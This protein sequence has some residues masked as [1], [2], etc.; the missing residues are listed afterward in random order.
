MTDACRGSANT[1]ADRLA[2]LRRL[3]QN[4]FDGSCASQPPSFVETLRDWYLARDPASGPEPDALRYLI[5]Q[6]EGFLSLAEALLQ[7]LLCRNTLTTSEEELWGC[8][9]S[10]FPNP[11]SV[12]GT[13]GS[14]IRDMDWPALLARLPPGFA[15]FI[16]WLTG[17]DW[18]QDNPLVNEL[19]KGLKLP[20]LGATDHEKRLWRELSL[21]WA[22]YLAAEQAF[23]ELL[24]TGSERAFQALRERIEKLYKNEGQTGHLSLRTFYDLWIET[25]ETAH[26][27]MIRSDTYA[28]VQA[29]LVNAMLRCRS[30]LQQ[31]TE[32][33]AGMFDLPVRSE[34]KTLEY[35]L[36]AE[37]RK[38][39]AL[40][41]E[42]DDLRSAIAEFR[43]ALRKQAG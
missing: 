42:Q 29:R 22:E 32:D 2:E 27:D 40:E 33:F 43:D 11:F 10:N 19:R 28:D 9:Y 14:R 26:E 31:I 1:L 23:R 3:W 6:G 21:A 41:R 12:A 18:M 17:H 7:H 38:L 20:G 30:L 25:S 36:H 35:R 4:W 16:P 13:N 24:N 34:I 37:R 39:R 8:L 5:A 15:A